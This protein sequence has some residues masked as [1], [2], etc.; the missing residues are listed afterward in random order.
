MKQLVV[1]A[2]FA[3]L[4]LGLAGCQNANRGVEVIIEGGGEFPEFLVGR[5]KADKGF[6]E[7]NFEPDGRISSAAL[8]LGGVEVT[9]GKVARFPTRYG[10][11]GVFEPGPWIVLYS[12]ENRELFVKVV[13]EHFYMQMGESALEGNTT[14][15]LAG[16]VSEDGKIWWVEW[17]SFGK[18]IGH[19]PEP[20]EF[21]NQREPE[22]RKSLIFE[23]VEQEE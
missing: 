3:V 9:P 20:N 6:W 5:W 8:G 13:I 18:Y 19:I 1:L 15:I 12:P 22:F 10:G 7:F 11:E 14:D 17:F 16:P 2:G 4:L 23:K 21:Y